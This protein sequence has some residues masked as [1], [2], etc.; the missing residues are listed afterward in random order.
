MTPLASSL[1]TA[2]I[3]ALPME[4]AVVAEDGTIVLVNDAWRRFA[5]EN[6]GVHPDY[7]VGENYLDVGERAFEDPY[8]RETVDGL[9]ALLDGSEE[10]L[11][12]EYPCHSPT[13]QRWF[14]LDAAGFAL[15]GERYAMVVHHDITVQRLAEL[16]SAARQSQLETLLGVLTHDIRN[17]LNVIE[18]YADLVADEIGDTAEIDTIR[19]AAVRIAEIAEATLE[20]T[21]SGALST[22]EPVR[23]SDLA[24]EAWD[25][26]ATPD[27]T[28]TVHRTGVVHGDRRLL[29]QLLENLFRNA[30]T[31][32]GPDCAV[33]VGPLPDG[34][35]VED[36]GPGVPPAVR[37][38][39]AEADFSTAGTGGLGLAIVRAVVDAH[40]GT[41][42]ITDAESGGA[43]FEITHVDVAPE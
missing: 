41:L 13:E 38:R 22:V 34:F 11:A 17:P 20:F 1:T 43:R 37:D 25:T 6:H 33:T 42:S 2:G 15:D 7:W 18:G 24:R 16:R 10:H 19:R 12:I 32:A 14:R 30:V 35:Y 9:R 26:V 27:A 8:A 36:D 40:G 39:A 28:V 3:A 29:L 21:E 4:V 5:D 23:P 31:H